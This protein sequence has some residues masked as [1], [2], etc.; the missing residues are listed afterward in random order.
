MFFRWH[1]LLPIVIYIRQSLPVRHL[2]P[3]DPLWKG[4]NRWGRPEIWHHTF[5]F[6]SGCYLCSI[7][8]P[9][10]S[11]TRCRGNWFFVQSIK[12][13]S[14]LG[15]YSRNILSSLSRRDI[16]ECQVYWPWLFQTLV[17]LNFSLARMVVLST[18]T[19]GQ[20][21][22]GHELKTPFRLLQKLPVFNSTLSWRIYSLRV[23]VAVLCAFATPEWH[24]VLRRTEHEK[25]LYN[26]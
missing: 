22:G 12:I 15:Y 4:R 26:S 7:A 19:E 18:T 1:S 11:R 17:C 24:L 5:R 20:S 21:R 16:L 8:L 23:M 6:I 10:V 3:T 2:Q 14:V 9:D 25:E 13:I